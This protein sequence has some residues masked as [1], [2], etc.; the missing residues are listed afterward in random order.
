MPILSAFQVQQVAVWI[1]SN[2]SNLKFFLPVLCVI[3]FP[4]SF[5]KYF[6]MQ[7]RSKDFPGF[8]L[9]FFFGQSVLYIFAFNQ[10]GN[11]NFYSIT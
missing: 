2:V 6:P 9:F 7:Q 5:K 11:E 8:I 3:C 4:L 10:D 1:R